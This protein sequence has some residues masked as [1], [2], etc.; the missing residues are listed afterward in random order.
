MSEVD[1]EAYL[2]LLSRFLRLSARQRDEI[3]RELR[4]H[5]EEAIEDEM[6]AGT[7]RD[8]AVLRVLDDFGDAAEL[9]ARFSSVGRKRR[10]IM[11]GT[12]AAAV[13]GLVA[14]MVVG[15]SPKGTAPAVA[16]D[17]Q[18]PAVATTVQ[19]HD[20][21]APILAA[22]ARNV[23]EVMLEQ[24]PL[25][26]AV[27]WFQELMGVNIVVYW[28]D[29][30][31]VGVPRDAPVSVNLR[32][33]TVERT[34]RLVLDMASEM[35]DLG[36]D[37]D[38]GILVIAS[39]H[40]LPDRQVTEVYE[41]RDLLAATARYARL[42]DDAQGTQL[43][44][45]TIAGHLRRGIPTRED[46]PA[47][48]VM[49]AEVHSAVTRAL[50]TYRREVSPAAA[51]TLLVD[52]IEQTIDPDAW[53]CNGGMGT[54]RILNGVLVVRQTPKIHEEVEQLLDDLREAGA[55]ETQ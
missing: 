45:D 26:V 51:E 37:I 7:P 18:T 10:W 50:E 19:E 3:R 35:S 2:G 16:D 33:V 15:F 34:L 44:A 46:M 6:A 49:Q 52:L 20:P 42:E 22:L 5:L 12:M 40:R 4:A 27:E 28:A 38:D 25:D 47:E 39:R 1:F 41:V 43:L 53:L 31:N 8:E 48:L 21:D 9:A 23:P 54:A 29:L 17:A 11:R 55:A 32:N 36:Y 24:V 30:E 13:I 14:F